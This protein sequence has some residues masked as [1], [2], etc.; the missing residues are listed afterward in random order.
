MSHFWL[1][2]TT[3]KMIYSQQLTVSPDKTL[4][5]E[6]LINLINKY[7]GMTADMIDRQNNNDNI[8]TYLPTLNTYRSAHFEPF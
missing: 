1:W 3:A 7:F 5:D 4:L 6:L 2:S 8:N